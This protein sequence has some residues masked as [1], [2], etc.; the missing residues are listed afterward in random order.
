MTSWS[1][2][3]YESLNEDLIVIIKTIESYL[4][5]YFDLI[6]FDF[7]VAVVIDIYAVK[8]CISAYYLTGVLRLMVKEE[9]NGE[10]S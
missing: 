4:V 1:S 2:I 3:R 5:G 8:Y 7:F 6:I 9:L 10:Q